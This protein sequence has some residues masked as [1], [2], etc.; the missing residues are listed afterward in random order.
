MIVL[1][2]SFL[3][4]LTATAGELKYCIQAAAEKNLETIKSY[5]ER[6]KEF[7]EARIEKRGDL[8]LLR[9]GAEERKRNLSVM[10]RKVK[11]LFPDAYIKK[12]EIDEKYVVYPEPKKEKTKEVKEE[13][14]VSK[15]TPDVK[16]GKIEKEEPAI[17]RI[18]E[19]EQVKE[20]KEIDRS[21]EELK[22][23][24]ESLKEDLEEVKEILREREDKA[25]VVI[26]SEDP[27]YFEKFFYSVG[28]FIGGLFL[29]TWILLILLYR[30]VGS[31]NFE[32]TNLLNDMFK[33]IKVLNLL[34]KGKVVKMEGGKLMV[35]DPQK[36]KWSEV[37]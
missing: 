36:D 23:Q 26:K 6:V 3:V 28:I 35:Y 18:K 1:L 34:S 20:T 27:A 10:Y 5:Y 37:E 15:I 31:T 30:K 2:V 24:I 22:D 17:Q 7:P 12:C 25:P 19:V 4:V 8:Y 14:T 13:A 9:V 21:I 29:F 33:L 16:E 32:N 11:N